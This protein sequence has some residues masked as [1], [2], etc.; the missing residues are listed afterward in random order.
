[1]KFR[2]RFRIAFG[3]LFLLCF[4]LLI[5]GP[6]EIFFANESEFDFIYT[7]F[8]GYLALGALGLTAIGAGIIGLLPEKVYKIILAIIFGISIAGYLQVMFLNKNLDLLGVNPEGYQPIL[9][10]VIVS[11]ICWCVVILA[12][13]M[14]VLW[15]KAVWKNVFVAWWFSYFAFIW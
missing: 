10:Q 12:A 14:L 11:L 3:I 13:V 9:S 1:M 7:E 4:M 8:A 6:A 2:E 5:F 15:K